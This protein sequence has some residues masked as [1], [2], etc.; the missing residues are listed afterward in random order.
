MKIMN[1]IPDYHIRKFWY[2]IMLLGAILSLGFGMSDPSTLH[3]QQVVT[4]IPSDTP[5]TTPI[6]AHVLSDGQFVY[7]PNVGDFNLKDYLDNNAP[8]L[9]KYGDDLYG[10]SEYFSI[11]P[12]IYLTLLE[13][14]SRFLTTPNNDGI[15]NPFGIEG[16][17]FIAQIDTIS[18]VMVDAYYLHL[19]SY[20]SL[21]DSERNLPSI[22]TNAGDNVQVAPETNAGTYAVIAA[23]AKIEKVS[24]IP[25][26]LDTGQ[27]DGFYQTYRKLF[28]DDPLSEENHIYNSG[29]LSLLSAPV[30]F[31]QLPYPRGESWYFNGVHN[32]NGGSYGDA[33]TD[34][35]SIDFF[36]DWGV[37]WDD[38]TSNMW[39]VAAAPG[40][41]KKI[42][43]CYFKIIHSEGWETVYYH[44]EN[45]Q[46]F[47]GS[48]L[49]NA[50]I[51]VIA[52]TFGEAICN[53]GYSSGP[54]VHLALKKDGAFVALDGNLLSG[55]VIHSGRWQYDLDK[56]YMWLEKDGVRKY[57]GDRV[58][59]EAPVLPPANVQ[60]SDGTYTDKVRVSWTASSEATFYKVYRSTSGTATKSLL[61]SPT[62][63]VFGDT[64]ATP[65][66]T[67]FYWVKACNIFNCSVYSIS[68]TGWR[69]LSIPV[70]LQAGDGADT[71]KV[72]VSWDAS[73]QA[74]FYKVYRATGASEMK[75]LLGSPTA[76]SFDDSTASPGLTYFYWV[77]GCNAVICSDYSVDNT[78]W[79]NLSF[80]TNLQASD[81]TYTDKV[82]VSWNAS[83]GATSYNVYR[84]TSASETKSLLG[85][86]ADTTFDDTTGTPGLTYTYWVTA[87]NAANC[88]DFS[89]YDTGWRN[90]SAPSN[91]Q[92]SDGAY[93]DK[94]RVSWNPSSG[95]T[96]YKVYRATSGTA[97]KSLLGNPA[98][99]VF[100]DITAIPGLTYYYW[101]QAC[102]GVRCSVYS[103]ANT[104]W[105]NLTAP[106][107][108]QAGDGADTNKVRVSWNASSSATS[109]NVY[110]ATSATDTRSLLGSPTATSFVDSTATPG[111][112]YFYW[113]K[114][115]RGVNCSADS[116]YDT[117]WR[118]LS[119]PTN[120][121]AG[122]GTYLDRVRV[123]WNASSG[124]TNY[125]VY[126][127]TSASETKS[128][129][130]SPA[131][132]TFDDTTGTPGLTYTY[133]V[134][135]CNAANCSDF[136]YYDTGWR[137]LSAPSN[138]QASDGAYTDK[139]R[140]SWNPSSGATS[141]K[142]YRA[143]SGTTTKSLLGSPAGTA[144]ADIT[145]TPGL[146]YYYWVKACSGTLCSVYS[147]ANTGWR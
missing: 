138:L 145:A 110:R 29:E 108:L 53:G 30:N 140:V 39:V 120:L 32:W 94:V 100:A 136:S 99:T 147:T 133:W 101:V 52:N 3:T 119:F 91:L 87:C 112:T 35:S 14:H 60:A 46:N 76:T 129:L 130:G 80:P 23:L 16:N 44:L 67:Y 144:F 92:A 1:S 62:G 103:T 57:V 137:N 13:L 83:S 74:T 109:Y 115:C 134:T 125:N 58:L 38:D 114:A 36:Y 82:R 75:S 78:G 97:T 6:S 72:R 40:T 102:S 8:H 90:L 34:A 15:E 50:R 56:D 106:S 7:G 121:L 116:T 104:G 42:S 128:L 20:S 141:Y 139:V 49:Q 65:G 71:N 96:S 43:N 61:G 27:P 47:S 26:K 2:G 98:G 31:L 68:N 19:Y 142:V 33:F 123:S 12:K 135:A 4:E 48:I 22:Q 64:T 88:S 55:W 105:R 95:A 122:D 126:R 18:K 25:S 117:G 28:P 54:H 45:I 17:N 89:Y 146:T 127:A 41:P 73:S 63:T 131:D 5:G 51:G 113:V 59:S 21:P 79:R 37:K 118:N 111:V 107:G 10:R 93:T 124:A 24:D 143:T 81:G 69:N 85:S 84:A 132:T 77:K 9:S 70:N 86:P 11:N 66:V